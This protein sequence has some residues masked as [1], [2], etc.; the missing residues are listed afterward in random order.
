MTQFELDLTNIFDGLVD[1]DSQTAPIFADI[2]GDD[3]QDAIVGIGNGTLEYFLNTGSK[4][5]AVLTKQTDLDNPFDRNETND[6]NGA[7]NNRI[8]VGGSSNLDLVDIDG[9]SDLDLFV[10]DSTGHIFFY[11]NTG[12]ATTPTFAGAASNTPNASTQSGTVFGIA[13]VGQYATLTFVD[14]DGDSDLDIFI[15]QYDKI[16]YYE[17]QGSST[18][19]NFVRQTDA[20]NPLNDVQTSFTAAPDRR[21]DQAFLDFDLDGDLDAFIGQ[22]NGEILYYENQGTESE[23]NFVQKTGQDNP[24][25][26]YNQSAIVQNKERQLPTPTFVDID[27]DGKYEAFIGS[28]ISVEDN[29]GAGIAAF[30]Q[31]EPEPEPEPEPMPDPKPAKQYKIVNDNSHPLVI[32]QEKTLAPILAKFNN[33]DRFDILI[34]TDDKKLI[35]RE[36]KENGQFEELETNPFSEL[37][38]DATQG[39]L[40]PALVDI[41]ADND[42][43]LFI[44]DDSGKIHFFRNHRIDATDS[45]DIDSFMKEDKLFGLEDVAKGASPTFITDKEGKVKWAFIGSESDQAGLDNYL[46]VF[47]FDESKNEFVKVEQNEDTYP[48]KDAQLQIADKQTKIVPAFGDYDRDGDVDA[49]IGQTDVNGK[50]GQLLYFENIETEANPGLKFVQ[51][52]DVGNPFKNVNGIQAARADFNQISPTVGDFTGDGELEVF[53]GTQSEDGMNGM[54]YLVLPGMQSEPKDDPKPKTDF[55]VNSVGLTLERGSIFKMGNANRGGRIKFQ[56]KN[57][58]ITR[59]SEIT[60]SFLDASDNINFSEVLFSTLPPEFQPRGFAFGRQKLFLKVQPAQR[61]KVN[62][63]TVDRTIISQEARIVEI[64]PGQF[65]LK[66][67]GGITIELEQSL[68]SP[69]IG[70]GDRQKSGLEI[71]DLESVSGVQNATF[72]VTREANYTNEVYFYRIDDENGTI[73]GLAPGQTGYAEAAIRNRI[74]NPGLQVSDQGTNVQNG[75]FDGGF[76]YAP[77]IVVNGTVNDFLNLNPNNFVGSE[78]QAYFVFGEANSD[79][80]DHI[81]LLGNNAFGF[82]DLPNLGDNDYNDIVVEAVFA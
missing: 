75:S 13:S 5:D 60:I 6:N 53:A 33:D 11:E 76:L 24:F 68:E 70:V 44:G 8:D 49:I 82:E 2:N 37:D 31:V 79:R 59:V 14:I 12:N 72:T 15:G 71:L 39:I 27:N 41:D 1:S 20:N 29:A 77:V 46:K 23:P 26:N 35:Y 3:L 38:L 73:D 58:N 52:L 22:G 32:T 16:V 36:Q 34:G 45:K 67:P 69:P 47:W 7:N 42:L 18:N 40:K 65:E 66:F 55:D 62:I 56:L 64:Q 78:V 28:R 17:N 74:D 54:R 9:D 10:G 43:D 4:T 50:E 81:R 57:I 48:F 25:D 21:I 51:R 19:G 63:Q 80:A 61:F 30:K